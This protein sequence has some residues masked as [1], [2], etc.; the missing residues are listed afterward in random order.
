MCE[1]GKALTIV[2]KRTIFYGDFFKYFVQHG[3]VQQS[4]FILNYF[5]ICAICGCAIII[6]ITWHACTCT[7]T[8]CLHIY[9]TGRS[10]NIMCFNIDY[11]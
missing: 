5:I 10:I 3:I 11:I 4:Y 8:K 6:H 1:L 7:I 9:T 2:Y